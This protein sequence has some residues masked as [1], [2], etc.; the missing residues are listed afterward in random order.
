MSATPKPRSSSASA[1]TGQTLARAKLG[2]LLTEYGRSVLD[3]PRRFE[4]LLR[5]LCGEHRREVSLLV[6]A[7][8]ERVPA[9][10]LAA[11]NGVPNSIIIAQLAQRLHDNLGLAEPFAQWSV[12]TW[13]LALGVVTEKDL[14]P[15]VKRR[16]RKTTTATAAPKTSNPTPA[17]P[18]DTLVVSPNGKGNFRTIAAAIAK[19]PD[20]GRILVRPGHYHESLTLDKPLTM[21]GD[22]LVNQIVIEA[23]DAPCV[24]VTALRSVLRGL[25]FIRHAAS[26]NAP[27]SSGFGN[28]GG[29]NQAKTTLSQRGAVIDH[30]R[31]VLTLE[32]CEILGQGRACLA[33]GSPKAT[34]NA[35]NCV[36]YDGSHT[37]VLVYD[38]AEATLEDCDI[39]GHRQNGVQITQGANPTLRRCKIRQSEVGVLIDDFGS[40]TLEGC[41]I[42]DNQFQ[43]VLIDNGSPTLERCQ[44]QRNEVGIWVER[45]GMGVVNHCDLTGNRKGAWRVKSGSGVRHRG[46]RE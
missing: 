35:R 16:T 5:D 17:L 37:G 32:E 26:P 12:E 27:L 43:G 22:G 1:D 21:I 14:T 29:T 42:I 39:Y 36:I 10:L 31:G 9:D 24:M 44:V 38:Y 28:P 33:V 20:N 18:K 8:K 7:L 6:S 30:I 11:S 3:D 23:T 40:G 25:T 13:A 2:D 41:A 19:A 4:A 46:N 15:P 34:L 45:G